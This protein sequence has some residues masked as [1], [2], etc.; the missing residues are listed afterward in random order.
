MDFDP[1]TIGY[2]Q[3][4]NHF[5]Q[6]HNPTSPAWST[7]YMSAVFYHDPVQEAMA[8]ESLSREEKRRGK[9]I[10]T[11]ILPAGTF[12]LAETYHQKYYLKGDPLF[13]KEIKRMYPRDES[14]T[15][16]TVAARLNGYLGGNGTPALLEKESAGYG[17]SSQAEEKL[18]LIVEKLD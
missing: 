13:I 2:D 3:L 4:L 1:K 18:R 10:H 12:Y 16:S 8:R 15:D 7:Q 14:I 11:K 9:K 6:G 17:L 5:W